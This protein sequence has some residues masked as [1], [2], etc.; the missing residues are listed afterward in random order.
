MNK[1]CSNNLK[2]SLNEQKIVQMILTIMWG[3]DLVKTFFEPSTVAR[4]PS[5]AATFIKLTK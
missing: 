5:A 1:K 2:N 4:G 3:Y